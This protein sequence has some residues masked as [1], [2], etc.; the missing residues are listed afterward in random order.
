[1]TLPL[2]PLKLRRSVG[3]IE[4]RFYDYRFVQDS[5]AAQGLAIHEIIPPDVRGFQWTLLASPAAAGR[6]QASFPDDVAPIGIAE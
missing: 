2:P 6:A 4:D 1:M 3:P 5:F